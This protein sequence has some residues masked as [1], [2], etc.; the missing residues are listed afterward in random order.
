MSSKGSRSTERAA[1]GYVRTGGRLD[2]FLHSS[3]KGGGDLSVTR[4]IMALIM[5]RPPARLV[6]GL[7]GVEAGGLPHG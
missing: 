7:A 5:H 4:C 1:A 6:A 2:H 3:T